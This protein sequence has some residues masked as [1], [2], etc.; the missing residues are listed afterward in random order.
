MIEIVPAEPASLASPCVNVCTL[1]PATGWCRGCGRSIA[2]I[3]NWSA[4]PA[5]ER[6]AILAAL[7]PRMARLA[8]RG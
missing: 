3:S 1:D 2:E 5:A 6:R 8:G 7:P 4:K